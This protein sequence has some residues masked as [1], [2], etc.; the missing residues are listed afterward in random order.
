V[1][2]ELLTPGRDCANW[3]RVK[4][5][6]DKWQRQEGV[7]RRDGNGAVVRRGMRRRK[8]TLGEALRR[9]VRYFSDGAVFGSR[10]FVD[11]FFREQRWRFGPKRTSGARPLRKIDAPG[12]HVLRDLRVNV[13]G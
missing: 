3:N 5:V 9:R 1:A 7:E 12:L 13:L 10:E 4:E 8:P 6:Y 11:A 2:V